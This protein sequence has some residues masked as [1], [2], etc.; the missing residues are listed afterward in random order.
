MAS[1]RRLL[2]SETLLAP[3]A[4]IDSATRT[5]TIAVP[6]SMLGVSRA[7][8]FKTLTSAEALK[9][10]GFLQRLGEG[11]IRQPGVYLAPLGP[12]SNFHYL[13][14]RPFGEKHGEILNGYRLG[15]WPAERWIMA[16]NYFNPD[17][18]VEVTEAN[19]SL[20][21]SPHFTLGDFVTHDQRDRWPKYVVLE[22]KLIDKLELIVQEM[23]ARGTP[24]TNV[25]VLSGFRA[26]YYN[27][28]GVGEGMARASRHMFG[29]AADIYIDNDAD[30]R[31][32]DLDG[33]GR[34]DLND[35][36]P[37]VSAIA[38][39][40]QRRPELKGGLG[41]Y[42]EMGPTG[43][44]AHVDVRGTSARWESGWWKRGRPDRS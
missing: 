11:A 44:F 33:N 7:L 32:D 26:P 15:R 27:E 5:T 25:R 17:G 35:I 14:L 42:S 6:D 2:S 13:V 29:D 10:P 39:V 34:V 21:L 16:R 1:G 38:A 19:V 20:A 18:F 4:P 28:R 37:L 23:V 24:V 43:P 22:E 41:T 8:R 31:M 12:D 3:G 9:V 30:G 40:E 36:R